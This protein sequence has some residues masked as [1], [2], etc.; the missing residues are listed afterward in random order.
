MLG[1]KHVWPAPQCRLSLRT[2]STALQYND[3]L[4]TV[5]HTIPLKA[6]ANV[7]STP[8]SWE[9]GVILGWTEVCGK[10]RPTF[11]YPGKLPFRVRTRVPFRAARSLKKDKYVN[12]FEFLNTLVAFSQGC[13]LQT[14]ALST[15]HAHPCPFLS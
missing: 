7:L 9:N 8:H 12:A 2:K 4:C 5:H 15:L 14:G 6:I 1:N 13:Q 11:I 10:T 3:K